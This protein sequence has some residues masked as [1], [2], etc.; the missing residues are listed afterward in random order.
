MIDHHATGVIGMVRCA[1]IFSKRGLH[2]CSPLS[3]DLLN[4]DFAVLIEG[5]GCGG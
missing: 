4:C 2:F 1:L 3:I 5:I